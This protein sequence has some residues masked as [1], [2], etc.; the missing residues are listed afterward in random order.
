MATA[1]R[2]SRGTRSD[3]QKLVKLLDPTLSLTREAWG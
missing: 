1:E 3:A 2:A